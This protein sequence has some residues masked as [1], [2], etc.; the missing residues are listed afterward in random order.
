LP[1]YTAAVGIQFIALIA[2][3]VAGWLPHAL[4]GDHLSMFADLMISSVVGGI[5]YVGTIYGLKKLRGDF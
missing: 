5:A 2:G 3:S 4:F 1:I